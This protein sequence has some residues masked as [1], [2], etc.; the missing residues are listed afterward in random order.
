MSACTDLYR[1]YEDLRDDFEAR[2]RIL[3]P[4]E[5]GRK[6]PTYNGIRWNFRYATANNNKHCFPIYPDF[7]YPATGDSW[8][9]ELPLPVNEWLFARMYN[10]ESEHGRGVHQN[11]MR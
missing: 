7:Y 3:T 6:L 5:G 9:E 1:L 8:R 2:I 11:F 10:I 4:E